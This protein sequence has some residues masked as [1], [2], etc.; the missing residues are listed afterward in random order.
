MESIA[1][2]TRSLFQAAEEEAKNGGAGASNVREQSR[3]HGITRTCGH[4]VARRIGAGLV[5]A[6]R[7]AAAGRFTAGLATARDGI[8]GSSIGRT[9]TSISGTITRGRTRQVTDLSQVNLG[10]LSK[11]LA[12]LHGMVDASGIVLVELNGAIHGALELEVGIGNS[13]VTSS[14]PGLANGGKEVIDVG[15]ESTAENLDAGNKR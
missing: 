1:E 9:S 13:L 4:A 14:D 11:S 8:G 12:D 10:T 7:L 3:G 6:A 15:R 5:I 2:E